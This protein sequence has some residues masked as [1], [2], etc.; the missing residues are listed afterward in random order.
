MNIGSDTARILAE[1]V[2][3]I[4]AGIVLFN[5]SAFIAIFGGICFRWQWTANRLFRFTHI[6]LLGI[7]ALQAL[8]GRLCPLT[9]LEF[10]LRQAAGE[11]KMAESFVARLIENIIYYDLPPWFFALV[12][13]AVFLLTLWLLKVS[14]PKVKNRKAP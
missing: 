14:P 3:I 8:L 6:S 12:Y 10:R 7:V 4:H 11:E 5:I 13:C 2:L 9:I 1:L